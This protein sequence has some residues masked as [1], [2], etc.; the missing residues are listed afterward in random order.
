MFC[1]GLGGSGNGSEKHEICKKA[2]KVSMHEPEG[3]ITIFVE[4]KTFLSHE[5][6]TF[7]ILTPLC[8]R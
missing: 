7:Y 1:S 6:E 5:N 8:F 4:T 3:L 2:P